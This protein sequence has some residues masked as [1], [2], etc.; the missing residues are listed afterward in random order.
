[1]AKILISY[2]REDSAYL[3]GIIRDQ[4]VSQLS[5]SEIF[6]DID[7]LDLGHDFR[8]RI[9]SSVAECDYLVA[10]IGKSW[11][12]VRDQ[13]GRRRLDDPADFVRLEIEAALKR[14]IPVIPL[15]L[16]HV[17]PPTAED[18]P[19]GLSELAYRQAISVRPP[20]DFK[21]DIGLLISKIKAQDTKRAEEEA[22]TR[23]EKEREEEAQRIEK[24]GVE[25][26]Q[27]AEQNER[28]REASD[29]PPTILPKPVVPVPPGLPIREPDPWDAG[30]EYVLK[31]IPPPVVL[32]VVVCLMV[33]IAQVLLLQQARGE[34]STL[35]FMLPIISQVGL[36]GVWAGLGRSRALVRLPLV[37]AAIAILAYSPQ[38]SFRL[39]WESD[40]E[41]FF[42]P[43]VS[44]AALT[45][46]GLAVGRAIGFGLVRTTDPSGNPHAMPKARFQISLRDI[47][48]ATAEIGVLAGLF[49][50]VRNDKPDPWFRCFAVFVVACGVPAILAAWVAFGRR[51]LAL[52]MGATAVL[53]GLTAWVA[54]SEGQRQGNQVAAPGYSTLTSE[55][56]VAQVVAAAPPAESRQPIEAPA[57]EP[58]PPPPPMA[59]SDQFGELPRWLSE[60]PHQ[61]NYLF[62][63]LLTALEIGLLLVFR[64]CGFCF[65]F[66]RS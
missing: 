2:R 14:G 16:D 50:L 58:E 18:L 47:L 59:P 40:F 36:L 52:R 25:R 1:M 12:T 42:V 35:W 29:P 11:L 53:V 44:M 32:L 34:I 61:P 65:H 26:A 63:Y 4:F 51:R 66:S 55:T 31:N 49:L 6:F 3:A 64:A 7:S 39:T 54:G 27:N 20:P 33:D 43:L 46:G 10:V 8:V 23:L 48:V 22:R 5:G 15:L 30:W 60:Q 24:E 9:D 37:V 21:N 13:A 28:E 19:E 56:T 17:G 62:F 38:L 45:A 57:A 41:Y